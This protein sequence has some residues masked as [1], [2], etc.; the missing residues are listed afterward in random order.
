MF[1]SQESSM[2]QKTLQ[3][4]CASHSDQ[5]SSTG[6]RKR[7]PEQSQGILQRI[8]QRGKAGTCP[9]AFQE[10]PGERQRHANAA[11]PKDAAASAAQLKHRLNESNKSHSPP[12][13]EIRGM[14]GC[15]KPRCQ[16]GVRKAGLAIPEIA[17]ARADRSGTSLGR[18]RREAPLI[19]WPM[20]TAQMCPGTP[21]SMSWGAQHHPDS[22]PGSRGA[23]W[24]WG[25]M[26]RT[27]PGAQKS[28]GEGTAPEELRDSR[29]WGLWW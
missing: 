17:G 10:A 27:P 13:R 12:A 29:V 24:E 6:D 16:S 25:E 28:A 22:P 26:G 8:P 7:T 11:A 18:S 2:E 3:E 21:I 23:K 1:S 20:A 5:I 14:R 15:W 9:T 4:S 19:P